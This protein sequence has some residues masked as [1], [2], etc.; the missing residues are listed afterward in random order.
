MDY[1]QQIELSLNAT[2]RFQHWESYYSIYHYV[3]FLFAFTFSCFS[4]YYYLLNKKAQ[5]PE[6]FRVSLLI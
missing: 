3:V 6:E 5:L 1:N 4:F 2:L